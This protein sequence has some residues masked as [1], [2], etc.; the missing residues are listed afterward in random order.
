MADYGAVE[1][2]LLALPREHQ[3]VWKRIWRYVLGNLR[4]GRCEHGTRATNFQ[5]YAFEATT[6]A[7]PDTEFSIEH[8]LGVTPHLLFPAVR[9]D[10][11][12]QSIVPLTVTRAADRNRVYL[13]SSEA[14]AN[15][16]VLIEPGG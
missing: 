13:S 6:H 8:G 11:V 1:T 2:D 15:I 3:G 7:T 5:L 9:L 10:S 12:N 14:S 16:L 4:F